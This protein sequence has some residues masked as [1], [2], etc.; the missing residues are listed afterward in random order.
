[1]RALGAGIG[2]NL[3]TNCTSSGNLGVGIENRFTYSLYFI[4]GKPSSQQK[5]KHRLNWPNKHFLS[6]YLSCTQIKTWGNFNPNIKN[7]FKLI[8]FIFDLV[9]CSICQYGLF[10]HFTQV[11]CFCMSC[12]ALLPQSFKAELPLFLLLLWTWACKVTR[13]RQVLYQ[14]LFIYLI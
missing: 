12:C 7:P 14:N 6:F 13:S 5:W 9:H 8:F 4:N 3:V 1:M 10:Y 11:W 2:I